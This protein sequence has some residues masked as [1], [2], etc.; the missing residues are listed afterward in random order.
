MFHS[1]DYRYIDSLLTNLFISGLDHVV[2]NI[3]C[4]KNVVQAMRVI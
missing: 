2:S 4:A 3:A 1:E